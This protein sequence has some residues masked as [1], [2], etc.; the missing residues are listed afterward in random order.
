MSCRHY[1]VSG[2]VQGVWFRAHTQR[3]AQQLGLSG[4]VRNLADGRVEVLACGDADTLAQFETLLR[5]G[6]Q[7]ARVDDLARHDWP[8]RCAEPGFR[9]LPDAPRPETT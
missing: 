1:V 5:R 7:A 6:P 2:R 9:V 8:G 3:E 4:W